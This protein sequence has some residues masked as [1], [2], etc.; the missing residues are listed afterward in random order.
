MR[1][2]RV[3]S[4]PI[5]LSIAIEALTTRLRIQPDVIV[6]MPEPYHVKAKGNGEIKEF[7]V[8][9][10]FKED[11]WVKLDGAQI[12]FGRQYGCRLLNDQHREH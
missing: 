7:L 9:N 3:Q 1:V 10:P 2:G 6:S 4:L 8:P 11:T 5:R 12:F